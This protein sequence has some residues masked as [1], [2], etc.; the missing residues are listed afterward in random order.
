MLAEG[1]FRGK[2]AHASSPPLFP[3]VA[4]HLPMALD[5]R[6]INT[7]EL[8]GGPGSPSFSYAQSQPL[9]SKPRG[10][11][12]CGNSRHCRPGHKLASPMTRCDTI[13]CCLYLG[14]SS[15][16]TRCLSVRRHVTH[17]HL[18]ASRKANPCA[19][20]STGDCPVSTALRARVGWGSQTW[21]S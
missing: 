5:E 16:G 7:P 19:G 13:D 18:G 6:G 17:T 8:K 3:A 9:T 4:T 2:S 14:A 12:D 1:L 21:K 11:L 20:R 10:V 15:P